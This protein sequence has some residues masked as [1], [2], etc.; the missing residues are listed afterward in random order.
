MIRLLGDLWVLSNEKLTHPWDATSYLIPGK[1]PTLIDCGSL[2]GYPALKRD[3]AAFG[4]QPKDIRRVIATHGHWDHLSG[5]APLREESDARLYIHAADR[6]GV[7][8][9]DR[10]LTAA[11]LYDQPFGPVAADGALED[12]EDLEVNGFR[13]TVYHTPGHS[14]GSVCL[15]TQHHELKLIVAGDTL[16]GGYHPRIRSDLDDWGRSLDRLLE[17][18]FDV[19]TIGHVHPTLIYDAKRKVREARQQLGVFFDPWF[20]PFNQRDSFRY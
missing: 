9:G 6:A 3:L 12:G 11:F 8:T 17:L 5:M 4:Y 14:P 16:W 19:V 2:L 18:E 15:W 7:E 10:D 13:F 1:E 20:R